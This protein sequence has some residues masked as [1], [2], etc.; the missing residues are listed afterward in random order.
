[1][2]NV[3]K[4]CYQDYVIKDGVL[5]GDFEGLYQSFDDPWFQSMPNNAQDT[6]K[7]IAVNWLHRLKNDSAA[8]RVIELGCRFGHFT[9][10]LRREGFSVTGVD[11]SKTAIE[12]AKAINS[13]CSFI[14]GQFSEFSLYESLQPDVF[15]MAEITWYVLDDLDRFLLD[16]NNYAKKRDKPTYLIH[17][18]ATY[19]PGVQK[20]GRGKFSDL[21][22]ILDYFNLTYLEAGYIM[23]PS[24]EDPRAQGTYFI[25][26]V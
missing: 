7:R 8:D 6:R 17:L 22:G 12:K 13:K 16:I 25:A 11:I 19:P 4:P 26:S 15:V 9:D 10:L 14:Q 21:S 5:V 3:I 2:N 1:M 23:T 24:K 20:Y 18:L